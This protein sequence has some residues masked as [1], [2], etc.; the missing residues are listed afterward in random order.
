MLTCGCPLRSW[1]WVCNK[2][3][4]HIPKEDDDEDDD[5]DGDYDDNDGGDDDDDNV[6]A[7]AH[8]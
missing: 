7:V 3:Q 6:D 5:Y 4:L 1:R 2:F 8:P